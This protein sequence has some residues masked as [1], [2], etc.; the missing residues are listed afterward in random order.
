MC[1]RPE[2][3]QVGG[4][5]EILEPPAT[6]RPFQVGRELLNVEAFLPELPLPLQFY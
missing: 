1:E 2:N 4:E 3:N 5:K 6:L